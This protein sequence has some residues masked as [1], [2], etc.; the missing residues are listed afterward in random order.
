MAD[1]EL[2]MATLISITNEVNEAVCRPLA[3]DAAG[4]A[5]ALAAEFAVSGDYDASIFTEVVPRT[6]IKGWARVTVGSSSPYALKVESRHGTLA[7]ALG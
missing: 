7:R 6:S 4:R 3:E 1:F 2:N 5:R